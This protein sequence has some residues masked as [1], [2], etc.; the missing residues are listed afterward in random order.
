V[1]TVRHHN[2]GRCT[3]ADDDL[4]ARGVER[5]VASALT[6]VALL[7]LQMRFLKV[8]PKWLADFG[9]SREEELIGRCSYELAPETREKYQDLH[10]RCLSGEIL[11]SEPEPILL[12]NGHRRWMMW[13][14]S[15]WRHDDGGIGGL[16]ITSRDV[17][18]Q[19]EA[20]QE[21]RRARAFYGAIIEGVPAPLIVKDADGRVVIMNRAMEELYGD[22]RESHIGRPVEQLVPADMVDSV[23]E[24]DRR[25]LASAEPLVIEDLG[26]ATR[27]NGLRIVRKTKVAVSDGDGPPY[28]LSITEDMTARKQAEDA[29]KEA[30]RKAEAANIAKSEFLANMS[31]EIRT[32]L[33]GVLGLADALSHTSLDARQSESVKLILES[34][35]ALTG[36]LSD[37]LDMAKAEAGQLQLSAEPLSLRETVSQAAFLFE[38]NAR[39]KGLDFLV[40]FEG[41]GPDRLVG[42]ALRI[43]QIVSNLIS[44]AVKFTS[45]GRIDVLVET[46]AVRGG[47]RLTVTVKDTGPGFTRGVRDRLF[48]RFEQGDGSVTRRF[49]GTGLGLAISGALAQKMN[50]QIS[51]RAAPGRGATFEFKARLPLAP[52][53]DH[54]Q[55]RA[56]RGR[57]DPPMAR[58]LHVLLVE[59]HAINRKVVEVMLTGAAELVTAEDGREGL[60]AFLQRGPFDVILMDTQMPVM[61]GLTATRRIRAEEAR[62]GLRRTPIVSLTANAMEHQVRS[63]AEAGADAHL[64]KPITSQALAK[65]IEDVV[66]QA[67]AALTPSSRRTAS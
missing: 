44:N 59:D 39:Q 15:P 43:K 24:E 11:S 18:A 21:L 46:Q 53:Q 45:E 50:G 52:G 14:A 38:A 47:A 57:S 63:A 26:M 10:R 3:G 66:R 13:D 29:L 7:D 35:K 25:V 34:G 1:R 2:D 16:V 27:R 6:S 51:C 48:R 4:C 41:D 22:R 40:S 31:H 36:I 19:V 55:A 64:P 30:L 5:F 62:R 37:V 65:V 49:G 9:M 67:N 56:E 23:H 32:P 8:S 42:D 12:P 58:K 20:E 61:D 54:A 28:I 60:E 33:N 17:T